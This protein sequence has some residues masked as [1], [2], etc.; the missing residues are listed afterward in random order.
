MPAGIAPD[1]TEQTVAKAEHLIDLGR[2]AQALSLLAGVLAGNPQHARALTLTARAYLQSGD[3]YLALEAAQKAHMAGPGQDWP[4]RLMA[5]TNHQ[6]GRHPAAIAA[7][8]A[9]IELA[10]ATWLNHHVMAVAVE[11]TDPAVALAA[12]EH[13]RRLAP[14]E[15]SIHVLLSSMAIRSG[16]LPSAKVHCREALRL[17]PQNAAALNDLGRIELSSNNP[18]AAAE[19][20]ADAL[21]QDPGISVGTANLDKALLAFL[22]RPLQLCT[23]GFLLGAFMLQ[24]GN[25]LLLFG[26]LALAFT[27]TA[28]S[29]WLLVGFL[30]L[31]RDRFATY[32]RALPRRDP[33][34]TATGLTCLFALVAL[35]T[36]LCWPNPDA[37]LPLFVVGFLAWLAASFLFRARARR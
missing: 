30:R 10:P 16:D 23:A 29:G 13:A 14:W 27:L 18:L 37:A 25:D 33:L 12:A 17:D 36:S 35:V 26:R 31:P 21:R 4:L 1:D 32:L 3:R 28:M 9:A 11:G 22:R 19:R 7:A 20:F 8:R 5:L 6:L 15:P 2:G 34:L 24:I